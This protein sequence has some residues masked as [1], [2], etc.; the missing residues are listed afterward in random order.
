MFFVWGCVM[1][2]HDI[3]KHEVMSQVLKA[4]FNAFE[5]KISRQP[6]IGGLI[7]PSV[8]KTH[9]NTWQFE[10]LRSSTCRNHIEGLRN[11]SSL[12]MGITL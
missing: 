11:T 4:T 10:S 6:I 1:L 2:W 12:L 5:D 8:F 7:D 9:G 3:Y